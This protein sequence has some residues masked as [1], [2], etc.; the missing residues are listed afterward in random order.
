MS[1]Y[2]YTFEERY[3]YIQIKAYYILYIQFRKEIFIIFT[4]NFSIR[5]KLRQKKY[6]MKIISKHQV[7]SIYSIPFIYLFFVYFVPLV[8]IN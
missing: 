2:N 4:N 7:I 3:I 1:F 5:N 6:K 8:F